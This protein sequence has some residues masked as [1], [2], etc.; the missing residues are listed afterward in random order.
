MASDNC[1][2]SV[3]LHPCLVI[4]QNPQLM[5]CVCLHIN[6]R[7]NMG[8]KA[9]AGFKATDKSGGA[10]P[11][12]AI[13]NLGSNIVNTMTRAGSGQLP[14]SAA[15][16]HSAAAGPPGGPRVAPLGAPVRPVQVPTR[17]VIGPGGRPMARPLTKEQLLHAQVCADRLVCVCCQ[18]PLLKLF[19]TLQ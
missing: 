19:S 1:W 6:R 3:P 18:V 16:P 9:K 5:L 12:T 14:A 8:L 17:V 15:P 11:L 13:K 4:S 7:A 10:N 2:C